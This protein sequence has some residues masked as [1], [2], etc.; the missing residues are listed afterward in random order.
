[1]AGVHFADVGDEGHLDTAG[2]TEEI[3]EAGDDLV[4]SQ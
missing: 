3:L 1:M 4:V 2:L